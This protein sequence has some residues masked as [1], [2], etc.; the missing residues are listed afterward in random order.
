MV[1][2]KFNLEKIKDYIGVNYHR[3]PI[4]QPA[5]ECGSKL[6]VPVYKFLKEPLIR[7]FGA[8]WFSDLEEV[9]K[10]WK[11]EEEGNSPSN[12]DN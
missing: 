3:W 2:F 9:Y 10:I 11:E 4:C 8:D 1:K 7:K 12:L 5:C 6:Q